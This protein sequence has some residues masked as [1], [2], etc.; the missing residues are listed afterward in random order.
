M[1]DRLQVHGNQAALP[2]VALDDLR[3]KLD[4]QHG[5]QTGSGEE[6]EAFAVVHVAVDGAG[7]GTEIVFAVQE[8]DLNLI[9]PVRQL[10]DGAVLLPPA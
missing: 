10:H 6:G 7:T 9:R 2:V 4:G 3:D 8:I 1:I 5:I